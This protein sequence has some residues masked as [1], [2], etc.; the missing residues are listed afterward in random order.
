[1][2]RKR[3]PASPFRH[4]KSSPEVICLDVITYIRF[5]LPLRNGEDPLLK[6]SMDICH[7]PVDF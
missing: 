5:P 2:P 3:N 7:E 4:F 6:R 1:M